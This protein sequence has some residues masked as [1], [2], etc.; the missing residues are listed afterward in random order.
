MHRLNICQHL[1]RLMFCSEVLWQH[2]NQ[3]VHQL[4]P[5][6]YNHKFIDEPNFSTSRVSRWGLN[7][8]KKTRVVFEEERALCDIFE[9]IRKNTKV[10][11]S[12]VMNYLCCVLPHS[13][14]L[15]LYSPDAWAMIVLQHKYMLK[16]GVWSL[17]TNSHPQLSIWG[18]CSSTKENWCI[19][20]SGVKLQMGV[21]LKYLYSIK[22]I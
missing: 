19:L 4:A 14:V 1:P 16:E 10:L 5:L 3:T 9:V 6:L 11:M 18:M 12:G 20:F 7:A 13:A 2:L 8:E 15:M 21:E 17:K 22:Y